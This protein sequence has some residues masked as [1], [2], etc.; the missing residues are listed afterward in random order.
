M[1]LKEI[2]N[3]LYS[4]IKPKSFKEFWLCLSKYTVTYPI[5]KNATLH[6]VEEVFLENQIS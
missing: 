1:T 4:E 5:L 2:L 6:Q 3:N